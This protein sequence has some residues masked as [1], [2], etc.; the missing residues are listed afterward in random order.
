M[1]IMMTCINPETSICFSPVDMQYKPSTWQAS[2][3]SMQKEFSFRSQYCAT[4][5]CLVS[6]VDLEDFQI[7]VFWLQM[8]G[9]KES[10]QGTSSGLGVDFRRCSKDHLTRGPKGSCSQQERTLELIVWIAC[11]THRAQFRVL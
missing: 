10:R 8:V 1:D 6:K 11:T 3:L 4:L 7:E 5:L 9:G 2:K